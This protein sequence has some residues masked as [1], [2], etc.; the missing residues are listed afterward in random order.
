MLVW[1][2]NFVKGHNRGKF[3]PILHLIVTF[4]AKLWFHAAKVE[5]ANEHYGDCKSFTN[6]K[7]DSALS[8]LSN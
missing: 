1:I 2:Q 6:S 3:W 4:D 5:F 8:K 7:L